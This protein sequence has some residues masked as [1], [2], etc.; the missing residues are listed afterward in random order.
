MWNHCFEPIWYRSVTEDW[1]PIGLYGFWIYWYNLALIRSITG[2]AESFT[3][4][5][6]LSHIRNGHRMRDC[7]IKIKCKNEMFMKYQKTRHTRQRIG[8]DTHHKKIHTRHQQQKTF[9]INNTTSSKC[10][11][12]DCETVPFI[13]IAIRI[14][15]EFYQFTD[16][17][18]QNTTNESWHSVSNVKKKCKTSAR[19]LRR[20]NKKK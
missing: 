14:W 3:L 2:L 5:C 17:G 12:I 13:Y 11:T 19:N 1:K 16:C 15:L 20:W 7:Y 8:K 9:K 10:W 6:A 4:I 18:T